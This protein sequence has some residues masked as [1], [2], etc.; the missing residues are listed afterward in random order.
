MWGHMDTKRMPQGFPQFFSEA[1]GARLRDA[2]G[3]EYL[4]FMCSFGPMILVLA[5]VAV[6]VIGGSIAH[7]IKRKR[8]GHTYTESR[9]VKRCRVIN[10]YRLEERVI[11][12]RVKYKYHGR[13]YHTRTDYN[14]GHRIRINVSVAPVHR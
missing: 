1:R 5:V 14:P 3:N 12:Y 11:G 7:E 10:D 6:A 13:I 2:D 4:D 9:P 8:H